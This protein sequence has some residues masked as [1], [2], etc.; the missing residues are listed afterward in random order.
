MNMTELKFTSP[1]F[2]FM[3][4]P[5]S[6]G[7]VW[8]CHRFFGRTAGI[9]AL[10]VASFTF[11]LSWETWGSLVLAASVGVNYSLARFIASTGRSWDRSVALG[12]GVA[13]NLAGLAYFKYRN[14]LVASFT[15]FLGLDS[16]VARIAPILAISFYTFQQIAFLVD[17]YQ[18]KMN[19][20]PF[21]DYLISVLFFPHLVSGPLLHY[22]SIISQ[23]ETRFRVSWYT[24][25]A[26]FPLLMMGLAKK[27]AIA[28][29]IMRFSNPLYA[30]AET[31][32][33]TFFEAW[34]A[35]L[36]FTAQLY[37]DFSGYSDMALGIGLMFG[38]ALP[39][40][41]F[42]PYK[43][44]SI[45]EFW[46]RWHI[47]LSNFLRDYLYI[48]LGGGRV[49]PVRRYANLMIVMVLG[50]LWHGPSWTFVFWGLLHG[51][52]LVINHLWRKVS[53]GFSKGIDHFLRPGYAVLTFLCV[54]IAWVFF[55]ATTFQG[56]LTVLSG[57]FHPQ[58]IGL[59]GELAQISFLSGISGISWGGGMKYADFLTFWPLVIM[60]FI[61]AWL[62][63]NSVE[64]FGVDGEKVIVQRQLKF[65]RIAAVTCLIWVSAFGVFGSAPSE[66]LYF[67]F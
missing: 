67:Q 47:T 56:A 33:L 23:F 1:E 31:G 25:N 19:R 4:L 66:F 60:A 59:P 2:L 17:T 55:K 5:A 40:N 52:F 49:G 6:I 44:T 16:E 45:I 15:S 12:V 39:V 11:Y 61:I 53:S 29:P 51:S 27:V 37:F 26:G 14:F 41:F 48:P 65:A 58:V 54:V 34:G 18:G 28:D 50:G 7:L 32:A 30:K 43:A 35:A 9:L 57:M 42:S 46:R 20:I 21:A 36:G 13:G 3:F 24:I 10:I 64:I 22:K 63:P 8:I 38:I 62:L